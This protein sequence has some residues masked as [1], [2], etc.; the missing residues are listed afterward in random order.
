MALCSAASLALAA[1]PT[2]ANW[3][4]LPGAKQV[5][6]N[7][8][9]AHVRTAS[10]GSGGMYFAWRDSLGPGVNDPLYV[11]LVNSLGGYTWGFAKKISD[12][13]YPSDYGPGYMQMDICPDGSGGVFVAYEDYFDNGFA[14][15]TRIWLTRLD[16]SGAKMPGFPVQLNGGPN[17]ASRP[18]VCSDA[19]NA[20]VSWADRRFVTSIGCGTFEMPWQLLA[21]KVDATGHTLWT[22]GGVP[23]SAV[24]DLATDLDNERAM[25]PAPSAGGAYFTWTGFDLDCSPSV[26]RIQHLDSGGNPKIPPYFVGAPLAT[27]PSAV[28]YVLPTGFDCL[29]TSFR[30]IREALVERIGPTG[31]IVWADTLEAAVFTG[32][33]AP[34]DLGGVLVQWPS[35]HANGQVVQD[36]DPSGSLL[37]PTYDS[38]ARGT[39][40]ADFS[41]ARAQSSFPPCIVP[42]HK[43]GA[44]VAA[45][46]T[47]SDPSNR[48]VRAQ[49]VSYTGRPAF[50]SAGLT[51]SPAT[52]T[53]TAIS[54]VPCVLN[55]GMFAWGNPDGVWMQQVSL[56][57]LDAV[58]APPGWSGPLVPRANSNATPSFVTPTFLD[59][60]QPTYLNWA[61]TQHGPNPMPAFESR[62]F[63]DGL[64]KWSLGTPEPAYPGVYPVN[65]LYPGINIPGGPHTLTLY[66]DWQ[67]APDYSVDETSEGDDIYSGQ[68]TWEPSWKLAGSSLDAP[69]G[70]IGHFPLHNGNS[71]KFHVPGPLGGAANAWVV[72]DAA[73]RGP[74]FGGPAGGL[75]GYGDSYGFELYDVPVGVPEFTHLVDASH[76]PYNGTNFILGLSSAT[77]ESLYTLQV[78]D[79]T[80]DSNP[81]SCWFDFEQADVRS[82]PVGASWTN[83]AMAAGGLADVYILNA[84]VRQPMH[85]TLRKQER[86][87]GPIGRLAFELFA[88]GVA[89]TF[90]HGTGFGSLT[91]DADAETLTTVA[92]RSG[93][94]LAVVYRVDGSNAGT[95]LT[96]DFVTSTSQT[97]DAPVAPPRV[98]AL[99]GATPNP[100]S[101]TRMTIAFELPSDAPARLEVVDVGGRRILSRDVGGMGAGLHAVDLANGGRIAPGVYMVRLTQ[102]ATT[103]ISRVAVVD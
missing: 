66:S 68:W 59:E 74:T 67:G 1:S 82:G 54:G 38:I 43:G 71:H 56:S 12:G 30:E 40:F 3:T 75:I 18:A 86:G 23:V 58:V 87:P 73:R 61:V 57:D 5:N 6:G 37:M 101:A 84:I 70:L 24:G 8:A 95:P 79:S 93:A 46:G 29:V 51:V 11:T 52:Q 33:I 26:I 99:R 19:G 98:L 10:D 88:P 97:L 48:Q 90:H 62:V 34:D 92:T 45:A 72:S 50:P 9:F 13:L 22:D 100:A 15:G 94:Y 64:S 77:P 55:A 102:G 47:G 36:V 65:N 31:G 2:L 63:F 81:D 20:F 96:Y 16:P 32:S 76:Q 21:Q 103:R 78:R 35:P 42:D 39:R 83:Q 4:T 41:F 17:E 28:A 80:Q 25:R 27:G 85:L 7:R 89:P 49:G 91:H 44:I 69:V 60:N 53:A 14:S